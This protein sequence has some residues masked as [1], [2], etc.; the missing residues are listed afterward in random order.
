MTLPLLLIC[1]EGV[2]IQTFFGKLLWFESVYFRTTDDVCLF[3][4]VQNLLAITTF[5]RSFAPITVRSLSVK[6]IP[7]R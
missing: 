4:N 3:N 7:L 6:S 5:A 1:L 2:E